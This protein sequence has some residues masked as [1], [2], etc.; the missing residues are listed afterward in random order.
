LAEAKT[1]PTTASV[2]AFL[3]RVKD[4]AMRADCDAVIALMSGITKAPPVLWGTSIVGFGS[5][6]YKYA[7]GGQGD[8]PLVGFSPRAR[9]LVLYVMPGCD[10]YD[11][12]R[13][14]LGPVTCGVSCIYVKRLADV[15]PRALK[16][17]VKASVAHL[18]KTYPTS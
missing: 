12:L 13:Q 7:S 11:A 2:P 8:W 10:G 17:L 3:A 1:R 5:Y 18:K 15:D 9:Q 16:A 6:N 14:A 4:P